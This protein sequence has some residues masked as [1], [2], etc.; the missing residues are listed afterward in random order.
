[1]RAALA[2]LVRREVLSVSADPLSPE[3]GSY[4][5]AQQMLRQVAYDT[6]SRRDRKTRHLKVAAHLR[7]AFPG[8]GEEV[9]DV[10]A[11]HYLDALRRRPRRPRHR[12]DPRPGH[13][14]ADPGRRTRRAHRRPRPRRRQ[15]RHRRRADPAGHP[16]A[17]AQPDGPRPRRRLWERAAEAAVTDADYAAAIEYAGR[18][19]DYHLQRGQARAAAR[20]QAI[21]GRA[22]RLSGRH[23]EARDQLTAA[24]GGPRRRSRRRHGAG[25][26]GAGERWRCSPARR[27]PTGSP[28]RRSPS[29]RPSTSAPVSFAACSLPAGSTSRCTERRTEAVA[30][31]R[32]A[33]GSPPDRRQPRLGRVL[34][35]LPV[36]AVADPAAGAEAARTA[37]GHLRRTGARDSLA[38]AIT[39]LAPAAR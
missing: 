14:R 22:L 30:Y 16:A 17:T 4:Q 35:N 7:A 15:L 9:T 38:F 34:L 12:P 1:M 33:S 21:A 25:P 18:A 10:I 28:P 20:A 23:A 39:N 11:R 19:R 5:F 24:V 8:D 26:G 2:D 31:F 37:V 29:A 27:T 13:H 36:L 32:E 3:R 6:L